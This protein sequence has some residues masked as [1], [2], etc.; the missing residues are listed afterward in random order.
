MST[1]PVAVLLLLNAIL[2]L[3]ASSQR[4][5]TTQGSARST[6]WISL[7]FFVSGMPALIYQVVWQRTLFLIYGVNAQSVAAVVTAFML[8]LGLGSLAG[9]AL[10]RKFPRHG[11]FLFGIAETGVAV[12]GLVSLPLFHKLAAYTAGAG[13]A[14]VIVFSLLLLLIPTMLMGASLP[15]L[16][17]Y[18]VKNANRVGSSVSTLYFVNT[19]GSAVACYVCAVYLLRVFGQSGSVTIAACINTIVGVTAYLYGRRLGGNIKADEVQATQKESGT[20]TRELSLPQAM[21]IAG[22]SGFVALG[23]EIVWFRVFALAS[24]DRAP[25]FALLLSTYLAGI[26]AGSFLADKLLARRQGSA[27]LGAIG[28]ALLLAGAS[29][30]YL[31]PLVAA[32]M[33][34]RI[35]FLA[36][37]P[38]FFLVAALTGSVLPL[39][40]QLAIPADNQAGQGVSFVYVSNILGSAVGSLSIGFWLMQHFRLRAIVF[41]LA[42]LAVLM[43]GCIFALFLRRQKTAPIWVGAVVLVALAAVPAAGPLYSLLFERLIFGNR[44]EAHTPFAQTVE[45]RNGV[46]GVTQEAAIFGGGVYDG[47]F[48]VNPMNDVNLVSRIYVLSAISPLP[49]RVLVIGLGGG[50]WGQ[51]L[52]NHPQVE[53]L[54]AVEINPG[55]LELTQRY[56]AVSSF[57]RNPKVT[58]YVDDGRRWLLAHPDATYD[59]IVANTTFNWRDHSSGLLSVEFLRLI[60]SHL[61]PG[62]IYYFNSTESDETMATALRVFPY[63]V[64]VINFLAVSDS[65]ILI[66]KDRWMSV[67]RQYH[68]DGQIVFDPANPAASKILAAYLLL[69]D[70]LHG[71]PRF[72]GLESSDSLRNRLGR[73]KIITD[74]NMGTEW[75]ST[76][77]IPWH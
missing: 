71:P 22:L 66:D 65:P 56:P 39:L 31:P 5:V 7:L 32:L 48:N 13:L 28:I 75:N 14:S 23:F 19:F 21:L 4:R 10:S 74:D 60:R 42:F 1:T 77:A 70:T 53:S 76:V 58:V 37:A 47:Y 16:V 51:I 8:G 57:L 73:A 62:G 33:S 69:A 18:L 27:I 41:G 54:D 43:G 55:Y 46:I 12:F 45:N 50:A 25:A 35:L 15:L 17:E 64:R 49:K 38:A 34:H 52:A 68:V 67:L 72:F 24:S 61:K 59:V 3:A 29:S 26:A 2:L 6:V 40:C 30:A 20:A 44:P 9:G 36:S 63:G 11:I